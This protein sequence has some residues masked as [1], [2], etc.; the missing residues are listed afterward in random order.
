L[1]R[2]AEGKK[3][4]SRLIARVLKKAHLLP[5]SCSLNTS[6]RKQ[7]RAISLAA[8]KTLTYDI[9]RQ[10]KRPGA[11]C[12][13]NAKSCYDLI[14]HSQASLS[15]Q[16][17]GVPRAAVDCMFTML[18]SAKHF[19]RTGYGDS[20]GYYVGLSFPKPLH[21]IG[22]GNGSGPGIWAVVSSPVLN[23]L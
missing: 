17:V 9:L 8:C 18:Q 20:V 16:Q 4:S 19:V 1:L 3:T 11:I 14:S 15:M 12:C 23:M 10:L 22:Q 7:H 5:S 13:N 21:G 2:C 6:S